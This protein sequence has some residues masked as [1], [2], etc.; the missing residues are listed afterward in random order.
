[1]EPLSDFMDKAKG[2]TK[3]PLG[4]IALFISLIYG[5]ACVVLSLSLKNLEGPTERLPL[6]WFII[7][8]PVFI[9]IGF[10]FLVVKHHAKLYA[11]SDYK[12]EANF[13]KTLDAR[14]QTQRIQNEVDAIKRDI[15]ETPMAENK[16]KQIEITIEPTDK[17][18]L[19]NKYLIAEDLALRAFEQDR[20]LTVTRQSKIVNSSHSS[21]EFDGIARDQKT[22]YGLDVKFTVHRYLSKTLRDRIALDMV[23]YSKAIKDLNIRSD[24]KLILIVVTES[25]NH[26]SLEKELAA[27]VEN[28]E[29]KFEFV[30]YGFGELRK[31]FGIE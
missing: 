31:R 21:V 20:K 22:L 15:E 14:N 8:F 7:A 2:L 30:I 29:F 5:L 19:Q 4:I 1:M 3:N 12:D 9:L 28:S 25:N 17:K 16:E 24:F 27:L 6:I 11:P 18:S 23:Y 26:L 13:V 10:I